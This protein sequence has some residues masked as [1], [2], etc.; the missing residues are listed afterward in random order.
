MIKGILKKPE[1]LESGDITLMITI[2]GDPKKP[3]EMRAKLGVLSALY[4][5]PVTILSE[6]EFAG[7]PQ[8]R[9]F[10]LLDIQTKCQ[11]VQDLIMAELHPL[12]PL[13]P[14]IEREL[15]SEVLLAASM[16]VP[17]GPYERDPVVA[18][19]EFPATHDAKVDMMA[20]ANEFYGEKEAQ[21]AD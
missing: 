14:A 21:D 17:P 5:L 2:P 4:K 8:D 20:P 9:F 15:T 1:P 3:E 19:D 12:S 18:A 10:L 16:Y 13:M 7:L 6:Q 11:Q